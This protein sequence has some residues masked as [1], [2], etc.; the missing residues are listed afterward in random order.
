MMHSY[1]RNFP[2]KRTALSIELFAHQA[3]SKTSRHKTEIVGQLVVVSI[4]EAELPAPTPPLV[5]WCRNFLAIA[6]CVSLRSMYASRNDPE[7]LRALEWIRTR[8]VTVPSVVKD[9][10][11]VHEIK[12]VPVR[13]PQ[14]PIKYNRVSGLGY[15]H[16]FKYVWIREFLDDRLSIITICKMGSVSKEFALYASDE[17]YASLLL[18]RG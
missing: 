5:E 11:V 6:D 18:F 12:H 15:F 17:K 2:I 14:H 8:S 10:V 16:I 9:G 1:I 3:R 13:A 4:G 7:H